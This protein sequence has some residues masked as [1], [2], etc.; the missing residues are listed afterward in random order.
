LNICGSSPRLATKSVAKPTLSTLLR[1]NIQSYSAPA[2]NFGS[3]AIE[4]DEVVFRQLPTKA[5]EDDLPG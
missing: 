3:Q 4:G 1:S 5:H 2:A